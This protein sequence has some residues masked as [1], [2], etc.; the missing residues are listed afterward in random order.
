[1][2]PTDR[3]RY[4]LEYLAARALF[5]AMGSLPECLGRPIGRTLGRWVGGAIRS[6]SRRAAENLRFAYPDA[7]EDQ[8]QGWVQG[9]WENLGEAAWEFSRVPSLDAD[10]Y[11]RMVEV[12]GLDLLRAAYAE[13][14]GVILFAS[15]LTNWEW[16]TLFVSFSRF[17]VAAIARRMKNPYVDDFLTRVRSRHGVT[18]FSH[19]NAVREGLRWIKEGKVLGILVDQRITAGG[20]QVPF[21]G[22]P[23]FTTTMPALLAIRT[24]AALLGVSAHREGN[25]IRVRV[26]P[27]VDLAPFHGDAVGVTVATTAQVESWIREDP[28]RWLWMHGRWKL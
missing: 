2:D 28:R 19:K 12:E 21:F 9:M 15:H 8:I 23:A 18:M 25:K 20:A 6:R 26:H 1:M 5:A 14:K 24:G 3:F 4:F 22:R 16:T 13:G 17:P 7:D 10:A 27:A 11:F